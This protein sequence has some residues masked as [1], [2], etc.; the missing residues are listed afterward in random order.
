[1]QRRPGRP[2]TDE[3]A[4]YIGSDVPQSKRLTQQQIRFR[5]WQ[6][7]VNQATPSKTRT[8]RKPS[9]PPLPWDKSE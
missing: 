7:K 2:T 6:G 1:M 5:L 8:K 4:N 9:M 3:A